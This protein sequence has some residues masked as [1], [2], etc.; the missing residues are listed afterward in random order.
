[1]RAVGELSLCGVI[2][3]ALNGGLEGVTAN[4]LGE[5]DKVGNLAGV[6]DGGGDLAGTAAL[7]NGIWW[8]QVGYRRGMSEGK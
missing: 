2:E 8:A 3:V 6:W 1:M 5:W 4:G 7:G